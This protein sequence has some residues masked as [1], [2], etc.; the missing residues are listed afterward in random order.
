MRNTKKMAFSV[1]VEDFIEDLLS[2]VCLCYIH[3]N[4]PTI[5]QV[6]LKH[7]VETKSGNRLDSHVLKNC[8]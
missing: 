1:V 4:I 5:G 8:C 7:R 6:G 3:V 2:L